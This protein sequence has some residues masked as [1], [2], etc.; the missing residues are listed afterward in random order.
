ME[1]NQGYTPR[2]YNNYNKSNNQY[3][4][5]KKNNY[6]K[7]Y[8]KKNN[9][10]TWDSV[11]SIAS[12]ALKTAKWVATLVN[13]EYKYYDVSPSLAIASTYNGYITGPLCAPP[14]GTDVESR[15]GDSIKMVN[16]TLRMIINYNGSNY[17]N[18]RVIVF[19]DKENSITNVSDYLDT[20]GTATSVLSPKNQINQYDSKTLMDETYAISANSPQ[21]IIKKVFKLELHEHFQA[22]TTT[23]KNNAIKMIIVG[24]Q[25]SGG[26]S[27][28]YFSKITYLDN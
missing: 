22:S 4:R 25:P 18:V 24:Q 5:Y 16:M 12:T 8:P 13:A 3:G 19:L 11:A 1:N 7:R 21:A 14:Q 17:E 26:A 23:V 20:V 6:K 28:Q 15:T 10:N 2:K 27:F 9:N